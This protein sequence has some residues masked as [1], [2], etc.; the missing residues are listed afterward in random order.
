[1]GAGKTT[2]GRALAKQRRLQFIDVD[3]EI[4]RRCGVDIP[5]IFEKEGE[6]GFRH[7]EHDVIAE[8]ATRQGIVLAT[9]GGSVLNPHNRQH[10]RACGLV[11]YLYTP[12]ELQLA[13]TRRSRN[14]PLLKTANPRE[15]LQQLMDLRDPLYRQTAHLLVETHGR[16]VRRLSSRINHQID[17]FVQNTPNWQ[18]QCVGD[19]TGEGS[20]VSE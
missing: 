7:R 10:L 6:D 5:Y 4:E 16:F 11:V 1:M 9:G 17:A 15:R 18:Q 3:H 8:L 12:V 19:A 14:R 2:I 13:R 20:Q